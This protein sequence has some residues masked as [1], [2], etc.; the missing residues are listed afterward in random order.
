MHWKT[1][2]GVTMKCIAT[3]ALAFALPAW[4]APESYNVDPDHTIPGFE[5]AHLGLTS[6]RGL[7]RKATGKITLDRAAK[8]GNLEIVIDTASVVTNLDRRD[9]L[10]REWFKLDQF[11]NMVYRSNNLKFSG[12][13]V[14]GADGELTMLGVTRPV[15][16]TV[17][18][19]KCIVHPVNKRQL[20]G[21]DGAAQIKRSEFGMTFLS[22]VI[23]DDV[24]IMFGIEAIK[25]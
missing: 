21:A 20:C 1:R 19:F 7:F 8:T 2:A 4:A 13:D 3:L 11:P 24:K 25:E 14:V 15:S 22:H 9:K 16:L 6:V 12:D 17:T 10:I 18:L 5:V 23:G